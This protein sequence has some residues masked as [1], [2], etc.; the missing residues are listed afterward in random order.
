M[1]IDKKQPKT[2][3]IGYINSS[4]ESIYYA[5][6][7]ARKRL[8]AVEGN[9]IDLQQ[10]ANEVVLLADS[11]KNIENKVNS[12]TRTDAVPKNLE[13]LTAEIKSEQINMSMKDIYLYADNH[14]SSRSIPSKVNIIEL[15]KIHNKLTPLVKTIDNEKDLTNVTEGE[16]IYL[17]KDIADEII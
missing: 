7:D 5:D 16:Y 12:I 9:I 2:L 17:S 15:G 6:K 8:S 10:T 1:N 13:L 4:G 11:I 3:E 14:E